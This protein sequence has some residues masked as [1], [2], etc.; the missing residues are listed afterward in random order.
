MAA[1]IQKG[2]KIYITVE[3]VAIECLTSVGMSMSADETETTCKNTAG[4]KSYERGAKTRTFTVEG[5]YT[6]GTTTNKDFKA[7][8]AYFDAGTQLTIV[9]GGVASGET[10]YT[11]EATITSLDTTSGNVGTLS[12]WSATLKGTGDRTV[13]VVP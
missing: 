4:N 9:Y 12:T 7:M 2:E 13:G 5:N 8:E 6:D 11:M 1:V 3:G 10:I